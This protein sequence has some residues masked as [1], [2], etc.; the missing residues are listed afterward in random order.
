[1]LTVQYSVCLSDH[2]RAL[3]GWTQSYK[4]NN[5]VHSTFSFIY[6][7]D[8]IDFIVVMSFSHLASDCIAILQLANRVLER[9]DDAPEQ[10]KAISNE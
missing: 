7:I 8:S 5:L 3:R 6:Y 4:C 1:V 2:K 10:F 9:F